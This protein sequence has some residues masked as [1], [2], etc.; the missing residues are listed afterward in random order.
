[1]SVLRG[2]RYVFCGCGARLHEVRVE[3]R[4]VGAY[5]TEDLARH[6]SGLPTEHDVVASPTTATLADVAREGACHEP[7]VRDVGNGITMAII[8]VAEYTIGRGNT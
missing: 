3:R 2:P 6:I 1:M 5:S 7:S 8:E 4:S